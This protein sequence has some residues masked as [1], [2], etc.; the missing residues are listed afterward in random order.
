MRGGFN[1]RDSIAGTCLYHAVVPILGRCLL[2]VFMNRKLPG[3]GRASRVGALF[4][5]IRVLPTGSSNAP[6]CPGFV[7]A[8]SCQLQL[9]ESWHTQNMY[10][11]QRTTQ[12]LKM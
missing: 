7:W 10:G 3:C 8:P 1:G 12:T 5:E 4:A 11:R 2:S 9:A 6:I